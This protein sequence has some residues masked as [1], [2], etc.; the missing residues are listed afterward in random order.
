MADSSSRDKAQDSPAGS[1]KRMLKHVK[2]WPE[3]PL[4]ESSYRV[5][6]LLEW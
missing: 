6:D 1:G 4:I 5:R 3:D 2:V